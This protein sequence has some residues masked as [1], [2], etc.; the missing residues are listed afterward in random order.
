MP[1]MKP[2]TFGQECAKHPC[3]TMATNEVRPVLRQRLLLCRSDIG[4]LLH[5]WRLSCHAARH[6]ARRSSSIWQSVLRQPAHLFAAPKCHTSSASGCLS[7]GRQCSHVRRHLSACCQQVRCPSFGGQRTGSFIPRLRS[8][9]QTLW[10]HNRERSCQHRAIRFS[11]TASHWRQIQ[12]KAGCRART[13]HRAP[14]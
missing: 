11:A 10:K 7:C 5:V 12:S 1:S 9:W 2:H 8:I 14:A 6:Q 13:V 3:T 4:A